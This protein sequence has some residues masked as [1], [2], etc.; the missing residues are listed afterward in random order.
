MVVWDFFHQQ[1]H[2]DSR[3]SSPFAKKYQ[4]IEPIIGPKGFI[5]G[6]AGAFY[7][8][9]VRPAISWGRGIGGPRGLS[10]PVEK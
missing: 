3:S 5:E 1:Y 7:N 8:P 9:S 6:Q 4:T 2:L 10:H